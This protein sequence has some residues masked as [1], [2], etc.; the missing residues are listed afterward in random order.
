[1]KKKLTKKSASTLKPKE[2]VPMADTP[3]S[4]TPFNLE[5]VKELLEMMEKHGASSINLQSGDETWRIRRGPASVPYFPQQMQYAP[6]PMMAAPSAASAPAPAAPAVSA[7]VAAAESGPVIKSPT[8]GTFY[9]AAAEGEAPFVQVG[10]KVQADSV[11]CIIEAM[12]VFNQITA[13]MSGTISEVL[14]KNG[15]SVEYGQ[16]LFRV[17]PN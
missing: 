1:M 8:V 7:P 16:A 5:A 17:K 4:K 15:D 6:Q 3:Q 14:V 9:A 12:K 10:S 13:E 2:P 11:V